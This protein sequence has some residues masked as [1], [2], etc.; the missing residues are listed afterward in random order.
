MRR[1]S[2][3]TLLAGAAVA[4][5]LYGWAF[6]VI[7]TG[8]WPA[9][10]GPHMLGIAMRLGQLFTTG[11][12]GELSWCL[13][14][15]VAPHPPGAYVPAMVAFVVSP[16]PRTAHLLAMAGVLF[17]A[18]D[19]L[20]RMTG[21]PWRGVFGMLWLGSSPL[22]WQQAEGYGVD[23]LAGVAVLQALSHLTAS[24]GL[25]DRKA[26][27]GWGA[28][29]GAAFLTKYTAPFFL[30][31]PCVAVGVVVLARGRWSTLARAFGAWCLV[32]LPWF[33]GHGDDVL[34]YAGA[35]NTATAELAGNTPLVSGPWWAWDNLRWYPSA[36]LESLGIGGVA[37]LG[38]ST[39][40]PGSRRVPRAGRWLAIAA[41]LGGWLLLAPQMQRQVRYLLPMLPLAAVLLS[42][43]RLAPVLL[44][45]ALP[46]IAES[47]AVFSD[48]TEAPPQRRADLE[49]DR[50]GQGWPEVPVALKPMSESPL[51]WRLDGAIT[52]LAR[53]TPDDATTVGLLAPSMQ[54][55]GAGLV[56]YRLATA[57]Y[58]WHLS[59]VAFLQQGGPTPDGAE[60]P[61]WNN[62]ALFVA[63]FAMGGWPERR[64]DSVLV[65]AESNDP[66]PAQ[67]LQ[68]A[69]FSQAETMTTKSGY[70]AGVYVQQGAPTSP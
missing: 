53:N 65:I 12:W 5:L 25:R 47:L 58:T 35:S 9:G 56:L 57:G 48:R 54:G 70:S 69:G 36:L 7:S 60:L 21:S 40:V 39:L 15:L 62:A 43:S 2:P 8:R 23:L 63:P 50:P 52:A 31:A 19:G 24:K 55:P 29:M 27:M 68:S 38:L 45:A 10:D 1:P 66:R 41:V 51:H 33:L 20:R 59:S 17:L 30:W 22:V 11:A 37:A 28:W 64:F 61:M 26:A 14:S 67:W 3:S 4:A 13:P 49:L 6:A 18:W 46:G 34:A 32:A 16:Q 44:F 42:T